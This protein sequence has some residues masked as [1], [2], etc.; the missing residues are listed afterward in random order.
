MIELSELNDWVRKLNDE[1]AIRMG[2]N[3][4]ALKPKSTE[5]M[6]TVAYFHNKLAV[7][8]TTGIYPCI[9]Y[10]GIVVWDGKLDGD[11]LDFDDLLRSR[12]DFICNVLYNMD[13]LN[14]ND[15]FCKDEGSSEFYLA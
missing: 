2:G 10:C 8:E 6:S 13:F 7:L 14:S 3:I 12:L 4:R 11:C 9:R 1:I 5:F 15:L